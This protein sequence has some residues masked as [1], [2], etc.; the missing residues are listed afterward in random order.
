MPAPS[1][2]A[3]PLF[4]LLAA[5]SAAAQPSTQSGEVADT[6]RAVVLS[7]ADQRQVPELRIG[8][9]FLTTLLFGEQLKLAG[10]ELEEQELFSRVTVLEDALMLIPS[11]ALGTGRRLR[12]RVRFVDGTV[13]ASADFLLVVD[14]TRAEHQ[15]NVDLQPPMPDT[16]WRAAE[17]ERAKTQQ[18][19]AELERAQKRPDGLTGLLANGQLDRKGVTALRLLPRKNFTQRPG[20]PLNVTSVTS[21]RALGVVAVE[22]WVTNQSAQ[23]WTAAGAELLGEGG[24]RLKVLRVWPLEPIA[25]GAEW[26]RVVVEAEAAETEARGRFT[27]S[28]WQE[29]EPASVSVDGVIFP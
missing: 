24:V 9:D 25:P 3:L 12:L 16:C 26:Q 28:L 8:P 10:V 6:R 18:C 5:V 20:E 13:P 17:A 22:L 11:R 14:P 1:L 15:V 19:Q 23:S 29:G 2:S 21:Y 4:V 7:T 27:L